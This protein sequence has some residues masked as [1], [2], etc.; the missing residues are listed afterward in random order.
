MKQLML[1]LFLLPVWAFSQTTERK[2]ESEKSKLETF[3]LKTGSLI[4]KE[5]TK[6]DEIKKVEIQTLVITDLLSKT[7]TK[8]IKLET[9]V[10]KSY[11]SSTKA[12]FLDADEIDGFVRSGQL[13]LQELATAKSDNYIEYQYTS[14]DG[15]Q[16]G[17]YSNDKKEWSYFLKL[18]KF[19]GDS[20]VFL[21]KADFE[22]IIAAIETAKSRL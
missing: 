18:E 15:F 9:S 8:G 16:S 11:G 19:D 21:S 10:S 2:S 17:A 12:C 3:S 5:F 7:S 13:L 22:K 6:I 1:L 20:Y 4:K 14:R